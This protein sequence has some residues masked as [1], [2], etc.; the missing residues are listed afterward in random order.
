MAVQPLRAIGG[1][2]RY[3]I[4]EETDIQARIA[5]LVRR[6]EV[7]EL[8]KVKAAKSVEVCSLC[9]DSSHKAQ[10]CLIM[11]VVQESRSDQIQLA[12][13]VNRAPIQP[14]LNT[15]N[16]GWRNHPNFSW[17]NDQ[18]GQSSSQFQQPPQSFAPQSQHPY[19]PHPISQQYSPPGLPSNVA[20]VPPKRS[21]EDTLQQF[22]QIQA[23]TNNELQIV[24]LTPEVAVEAD[25]TKE[26]L[27]EVHPELKKSVDVEAETCKEYQPVVPYPQRLVVSQ[28]N[29]YHTEIQEIFKQVKINIP[30]LDAIQQKLRDHGSPTI[31]IMISESHIGRAL[32]DLGSSVNLLPFSIYEQLG[33]GE[34]KKTFI[35]LQLADRSVKVPRGV[36]KD[37][38]VQV[39]KF[40]Y[41]WS[42]E[43]YI[44]EYEL[45]MN[46]FN[47]C[48]MPSG[49][50]DSEVRAVAVIDDFDISE[51]LSIFGSDNAFENDSPEQPDIFYETVPLFRELTKSEG[52][53]MEIDGSSVETELLQVLRQ[54][55]EAIG[56]TIADIKGID[57]AICTHNIFLEGY[58][59]PVHDA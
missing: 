26:K 42:T 37:V 57:P 10:D 50:D 14:F 16:P 32:L 59:R 3:K 19:Q 29:K 33:L 48:K 15:Y 40:Y 9:I 49:Y 25:E 1:G 7:M 51:L 5:A 18:A 35:V 4:K 44:W 54:H 39:D 36:I 24:A 45:E 27:E 46:V 34:L 47:A 53:C 21:L 22:M 13:R 58:A 30:L 52:Q 20:L 8:E 11:T 23:T 2:G 31:P 56:W 55:R 38:L 43:A 17:R 41:P 6:V 28:K 12:D